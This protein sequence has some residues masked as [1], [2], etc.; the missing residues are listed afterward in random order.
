MKRPDR[1]PSFPLILA[2]AMIYARDS[3]RLPSSG[4]SKN[5]VLIPR[6]PMMI[7]LRRRRSERLN[8]LGISVVT[9]R[10]RSKAPLFINHVVE[11]RSERCATLNGFRSSVVR[12]RKRRS[13]GS[14]PTGFCA[15]FFSLK[16]TFTRQKI[17]SHQ[18]RN[19]LR[20]NCTAFIRITS[21]YV[22]PRRLI[23][24]K[25]NLH[26]LIHR[27]SVGSSVRRP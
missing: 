3:R 17:I 19:T 26:F 11:T 15:F 5:H 14:S 23:N 24:E 6:R 7:D 18:R 8:D 4:A 22:S 10:E 12:L 20:D 1:R 27:V 16:L 25:V 21:V 9:D 13:R 2:T